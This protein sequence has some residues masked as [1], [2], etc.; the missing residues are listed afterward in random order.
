[1]QR[2][3]VFDRLREIYLTLESPT[4]EQLAAAL[5]QACPY[6]DSEQL[7]HDMVKKLSAI[8]GQDDKYPF[9]SLLAATNMKHLCLYV[10]P[11]ILCNLYKITGSIQKN[12]S[13]SYVYSRYLTAR[14][15]SNS[16]GRGTTR[17]RDRRPKSPEG[18]S[19]IPITSG[20][21]YLNAL[22]T[23]ELVAKPK[24]RSTAESTFRAIDDV[25]KRLNDVLSSPSGSGSK[26]GRGKRGKFNRD[27]LVEAVVDLGKLAPDVELPPTPLEKKVDSDQPADVINGPADVING[28]AWADEADAPSLTQ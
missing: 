8:D 23:I 16:R 18:T 2:N 27:A 21:S 12:E 20:Q 10:D 3:N 19:I 11:V 25:N 5:T 22:K 9:M 7:A 6:T 1:M 28:P 15:G 4:G 13:N 26:R 17:S 24:Q 14:S